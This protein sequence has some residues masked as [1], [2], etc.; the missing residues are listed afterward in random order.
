MKQQDFAVL[1]TKNAQET[2]LIMPKKYPASIFPG[3]QGWKFLDLVH[4]R[5][6][7]IPFDYFQNCPI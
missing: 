1:N 4:Y 3:Y 5:F 2:Q 7:A 6:G